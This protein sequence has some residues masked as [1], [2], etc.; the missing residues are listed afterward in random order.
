MLAWCRIGVGAIGMM[1]LGAPS[2]AQEVR[3][4]EWLPLVTAGA[5]DITSTSLIQGR[6]ENPAIAWMAHEPTRLVVGASIEAGAFWLASRTIAKR[7]PRLLRA[8]IWTATAIHV[9]AATH[10]LSQRHHANTMR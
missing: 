8:A 3:R 2:E 9:F 7:K 5:L 6:E 1:L 4:L 10:N